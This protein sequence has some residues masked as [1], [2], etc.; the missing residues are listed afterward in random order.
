MTRIIFL[1]IFLYGFLFTTIPQSTEPHWIR[2]DSPVSVTLKNLFFIDSL[3]GWAAGDSGTIIHTATG[4]VKWNVQNSNVE[5]FITDIFFVNE[6]LGWALT[7]KDVFPFNTVILKTTNGG[8]DWL[9]GN[10][11]D[12]DIF[13]Q[14][15]F[16]LD[17]LTGFLGGTAIS[18]TSNGGDTWIEAEVDSNMLSGLP[19]Y[20]F[21]FYNSQFGY[22]CGGKQDFAGVVWKTTNNGLNWSATGVSADQLYDLFI[23]D[24]L[25]VIG[26][27]GD[28]EGFFGTGRIWSTDAGFSWNY[29]EL[30][31]YGLSFTIDFRTITEGWSASGYKFLFT[32]DKGATWVEKAPPDTSVIYDLQFIGPQT[33]YAV[34]QDGAILKFIPPPVSVKN[35]ETESP[36]E[37][38]L[39]QNF[40]NP[41]NPK[42]IIGFRISKR[43]F[44]SLKVYDV[45]GNEIA[46]L[47]DEEKPAGT[48]TIEFD[49]SLVRSVSGIYF[50]QMRTGNF[51]QSKKMIFLK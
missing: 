28:P 34:G 43:N 32:S 10:Y 33:G 3:K 50:Y 12:P 31:F 23:L 16:F 44:V 35:E 49:P 2:L 7:Q 9:T 18:F 36:L 39:Y 26:L 51:T 17:S 13:M 21:N 25:N 14:T 30:P 38:V 37:F 15:I 42:T 27:S 47:V 11:P 24:S 5:T 46:T 8:N 20:N 45:L 1:T 19:V 40:P 48:Y 29:E 6:N 4:G 22:A 41:F